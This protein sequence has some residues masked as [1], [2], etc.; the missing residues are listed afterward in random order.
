MPVLAVVVVVAAFQLMQGE[1]E[2]EVMDVDQMDFSGPGMDLLVVAAPEKPDEVK[3]RDGKGRRSKGSRSGD[4]QV[5]AVGLSRGS[6]A[7]DTEALAA[8]GGDE[9]S[10]SDGLRGVRTSSGTTD[11][12]PDF[13]TA[14][15][16]NS[17]TT[18]MDLSSMAPGAGNVTV[19]RTKL[20]DRKKIQMMVLKV[21]RSRLP[22]LRTCYER[23][24]RADPGLAG[25]WTLSFTVGGDGSV[26]KPKAIGQSTKDAQLESCLVGKI[27][28]W[29]FQ[30]IHGSLPVQKTVT[31]DS[32]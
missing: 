10:G 22:R 18:D 3:P 30:P 11:A 5:R 13:L 14:D 12:M 9:P 16:P 6:G 8:L 7:D 28:K 31:F 21:L 24:L 20:K 15:K 1:T 17:M 2:L 4:L 23:R 25:K 29:P 32:R 19:K 26:Q 27:S